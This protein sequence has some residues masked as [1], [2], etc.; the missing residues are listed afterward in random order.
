LDR[1]DAIIAATLFVAAFATRLGSA[2][3]A[4]GVRRVGFLGARSRSTQYKRDIYYEAFVDGMRAL[5]Y[6]EGKNL[7]IEWRFADGKYDRL[8]ALAEE[9]VRSNVEVI[10]TH[11]TPALRAAKRATQ[12]IPIVSVVIGGDPVA[13][14]FVKSLARSDN[15]ITGLANISTELP[16]KYIELLRAILPGVKHIGVVLN[17]SNATNLEILQSIEVAA[18]QSGIAASRFDVR[19][20]AEIPASLASMAQQRIG[21][22]VLANDAMLLGQGRLIADA[23][24]KQ[25]LPLLSPYREHAKAGALVSFGPN[26]LEYYRRAATYVDKILRGSKPSDLP[27]EMPT[28]VEFVLNRRTA[29]ALGLTLSPQV[30]LRADEVVD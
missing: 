29:Q 7:V 1:R 12:T 21:A 18:R 16:Q 3:E 22:A 15:N 11:G 24:L 27:I 25:H 17:P 20:P 6:T 8:P 23:A 28:T 5:G 10:V 30:L 4:R 2:D 26:L 14:G 13:D 9:L 19:T